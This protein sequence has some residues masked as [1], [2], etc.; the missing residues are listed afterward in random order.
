M[1]TSLSS[2]RVIVDG[3]SS[4]YTQ[5]MNAKV[6]ADNAAAAS[7]TKLANTI[8]STNYAMSTTGSS[9]SSL[10]RQFIGG[11][12][13]AASFEAAVRK[14]GTASDQNLVSFGQTVDILSGISSKYSLLADSG[15]L[16]SKGY[17]SLASAAEIVNGRLSANAVAA[18]GAAAEFDLVGAKL[19]KTGASSTVLADVV[20][21]L[22]RQTLALASGMGPLGLVMAST[23]EAGLVI[24]ASVGAAVSAFE[25]LSAGADQLAQKAVALQTFATATGL[26]TDEI[27]ALDIAGAAFGVTSETISR[28]VENLTA[29]LGQAAQGSGTLFTAL[30][31]TNPQLALQLSGVKSVAAG[32]EV[33][34]TAYE[35]A[36]QSGNAAGA[37]AIAR[38]A[39][40][41]NGA[42]AAPAIF[43]SI[44]SA[45][46]VAQ[47]GDQAATAGEGINSAL[48][49]V[50]ANLNAQLTVTK[51][52]ATDAFESLFA[53]DVLSAELQFYQGIDKIVGVLKSLSDEMGTLGSVAHGVPAAL[54][55]AFGVGGILPAAV[56]YLGKPAA[57][58]APVD[59]GSATLAN[60]VA[61]LA[62]LGAAQ[63]AA[64]ASAA[65]LYA[66]QQ[67]LISALAGT[68]TPLQ[69]L[70]LQLLGVQKATVQS[71]DGTDGY[72]LS[73]TQAAHA[74]GLLVE[75]FNVTQ[76]TSNISAMGALATPTQQYTLAV[77]KLT[78]ELNEGKVSQAAF[79]V[80]L[81]AAQQTLQTS[82]ETIKEAYGIA[83]PTDVTSTQLTK[84]NTQ[85]GAIGATSGQVAIGFVAVQKSIRST[86]DA[87]TV[88]GSTT[89]QFTQLLLD[90]Q[91]ADKIKDELLT[92]SGN[93]LLQAAPAFTQALQQGL[94]IS[95]AIAQSLT[96]AANSIAN[97]F[98]TAGAKSIAG[99]LLGGSTGAAGSGGI[100][101]SIGSS[102][103]GAL[104]LGS[105]GTGLAT[106]GISMALGA[107]ISMITGSLAK[108]QAAEAAFAQAQAKWAGMADQPDRVQKSSGEDSPVETRGK[109][110]A[111]IID[112]A[113]RR[114][115]QYVGHQLHRRAA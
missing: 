115:Q 16:A 93:A 28:D 14:L 29:G 76:L 45:G 101:G 18:T 11:Y 60:S 36:A 63:T 17:T 32:L 68:A 27:Q 69:Q 114:K 75:S 96:G 1:T 44:S 104:G 64:T 106:G 20:G 87:M 26:S 97:A 48:I 39:L 5:A 74:Q 6:A 7:S 90:L 50:L 85:M 103:S 33:L 43:G 30:L 41:K 80:G 84:F 47:L 51:T 94:T 21:S 53:A 112:L 40:G 113:G 2:L 42:S 79:N 102:I 72:T 4:G 110:G 55:S 82:T 19:L 24:A 52:N 54:L 95:Q 10:S 49:P 109:D 83:T 107:G 15:A 22:N 57:P 56:S 81:L 108:S 65:G 25:A 35:A 23:G 88:L 34:A 58:T 38:S 8:T 31:K 13:A 67:K 59:D 86:T 78:L 71:A 98:A 77:A 62:G 66:V 70:Q 37:A 99:S 46:G 3:D 61:G 105:I 73:A 92:S 9:V 100:L 89:P 12:G 111:E 91:N